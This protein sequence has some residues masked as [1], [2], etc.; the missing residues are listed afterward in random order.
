L[1]H[2]SQVIGA[3]ERGGIA[4][5]N[6]KK[7]RRGKICVGRGGDDSIKEAANFQ[8]SYALGGGGTLI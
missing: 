1:T 2:S 6:W 3:G 4:F 5:S 8:G 7:A